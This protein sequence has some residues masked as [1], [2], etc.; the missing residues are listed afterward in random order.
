VRERERK[1][2][3]ERERWRDVMQEERQVVA[4]SEGENSLQTNITRKKRKG[5]CFW[6]RSRIIGKI[7]I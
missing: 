4:M 5:I 2:V 6:R 7:G 3:R 1:S